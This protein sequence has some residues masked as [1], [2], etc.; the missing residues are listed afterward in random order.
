M[1]AVGWWQISRDDAEAF[2]QHVERRAAVRLTDLAHLLRETDGPLEE[3]DGRPDSLVPLW[4]WYLRM[5]DQ[6]FPGTPQDAIPSAITFLGITDLSRRQLRAGY[7]AESLEHYLF[8]VANG[9]AGDAR[10]AISSAKPSKTVIVDEAN[11]TGISSSVRPFLSA[12]EILW[13]FAF[14]AVGGE[15]VARSP[16]LLRNLFGDQDSWA[17]PNHLMSDLARADLAPSD[18]PARQPPVRSGELASAQSSDGPRGFALV[19]SSIGSP[20]E[21]DASAMKPISEVA[22]ARFLRKAGFKLEGENVAA[23]FLGAQDLQLTSG[24]E[25]VSAETYHAAGRLRALSFQPLGGSQQSWEQLERAIRRFAS[26]HALLI[27]VD[28]S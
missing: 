13:R 8:E 9:L 15:A 14:L 4:E 25:E 1:T 2:R 7:V 11:R 18:D 28:E 6:D 19:L 17:V 24:D 16:R 27:R 22:A 21:A 5:V 3:M 12:Q 26:K 20:S 23:G 10:W